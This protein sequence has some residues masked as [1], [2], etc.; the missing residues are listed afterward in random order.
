MTARAKVKLTAL[1]DVN[2]A[3]FEF[4]NALRINKVTDASNKPLTP[5]RFT[6]DSAIRVAAAGYSGERRD[7]DSDV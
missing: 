4:N 2:V 1:E 6:Q 5:E 3:T 7:H